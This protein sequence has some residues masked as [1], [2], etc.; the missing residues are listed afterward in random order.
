MLPRARRFFFDAPYRSALLRD[1][2]S[3]DRVIGTI[4][5][6]ILLN[7][8]FGPLR[9]MGRELWKIPKG[10]GM[11]YGIDAKKH[12]NRKWP[13]IIG[14][15]G[16]ESASITAAML[17]WSGALGVIT[18]VRVSSKPAFTV[19]L[20]DAT[21]ES[22]STM[23]SSG[24]SLN[25]R[26]PN[27]GADGNTLIIKDTDTVGTIVHE[28]GHLLGLGH[29]QD[30][31]DDPY[32]AAVRKKIMFGDEVAARNKANYRNYFEFDPGSIMLYGSGYQNRVAP[33]ET[34]AK[35][36]LAMHDLLAT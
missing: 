6:E 8:A 13:P 9:W 3:F 29:E 11:G 4:S 15:T 33:S 10:H 22:G 1:P 30:R 32:A 16:G 7:S 5:P 12:P 14:Y 20:V 18:F 27:P 24:D 36:V 28:L 31:Q 23:W 17:A 19:R 21:R 25:G 35:T 2:G 26:N 34:D